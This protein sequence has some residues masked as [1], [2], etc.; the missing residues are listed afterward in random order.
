MAKHLKCGTVI[1]IE[2]SPAIGGH[3]AIPPE[4]ATI[5]LWRRDINGERVGHLT[6]YHVVRFADGGRLLIHES[7]FRVVDEQGG[8]HG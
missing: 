8:R 3:P 6:E 1:E 7:R 4:R 5:G 2:G